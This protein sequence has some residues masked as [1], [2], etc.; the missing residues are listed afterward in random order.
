M[1][2]EFF[3]QIV[4][5]WWRES[6]RDLPW[7]HTRDP[8]AIVVS[9]TMAQQTQ[10]ARVIPAWHRFLDRFPTVETAAAA[11]PADVIA[12]WEGLGYN[13]RAVRLHSCAVRVVTDHDG[14][15]PN[16]LGE[17]LALPGVGSYTAR[18]ILAFAFEEDVGV[19]DTNVG[20]V[21]ARVEGRSFAPASAQTF[22]DALVPEGAGWEWN[23][24]L[25]DFGAMVCTKRNPKCDTCPAFPGCSWSGVGADPAVGSAAVNGSQSRFE[26]SDRQGRGR[27]VAALRRGPVSDDQLANVMCWTDDEPRVRR[28]ADAVVADGLAVHTHREYRLPGSDLGHR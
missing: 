5:S 22:A 17:L 8:W 21:L 23:Q 12:F 16:V 18:A 10:I 20:R 19:V 4:C 13:R 15:F 11:S 14:K 26:G 24:A 9:E 25:L 28:I 27:L 2:P 7:R 3:V 6:A 1:A